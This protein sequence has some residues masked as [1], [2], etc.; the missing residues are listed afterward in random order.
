[1]EDWISFFKVVS[2]LVAGSFGVL[3]LLTKYKDEK[4][5]ITKW[6]KVALTVILFSSSLSLG[7]HILE[8]SNARKGAERARADAEALSTNLKEILNKAQE[9]A[10]QQKANLDETAKL[11]DRLEVS[12]ETQTQNLERTEEVAEGMKTT[13]SA[14]RS[15]LAGNREIMGDLTSTIATLDTVRTDVGRILDPL[16]TIALWFDLRIPARELGAYSK[17]LRRKY[18]QKSVIYL[19]NSEKNDLPLASERDAGILLKEIMIVCTVLD[20]LETKPKAMLDS[21]K[22]FFG[23]DKKEGSTRTSRTYAITSVRYVRAEDELQ[24][25]F[26]FSLL[27]DEFQPYLKSGRFRSNLDFGGKVMKVE[28]SSKTKKLPKLFSVSLL[29]PGRRVPIKDFIL[30]PSR[31]SWRTI[32]MATIPEIPL[33]Q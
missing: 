23:I 29:V 27:T 22:L 18:P 6:G 7:L 13:V 16:G 12:L 11:R 33:R 30:E 9:T 20:T 17:R 3:G 24:D 2:V 19:S 32:N 26:H 14:Q 15:L 21:R 4:G 5:K 1:M 31:S 28:I 8:T 10:N 25:E